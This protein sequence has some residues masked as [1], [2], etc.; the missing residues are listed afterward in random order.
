MAS[1]EQFSEHEL[2]EAL[3]LDLRGTFPQLVGFYQS[4][5]Y[6]F[7]LGQVQCQQSAEDIMQDSWIRIYQALDRYPEE[8]IRSLNLRPWLFTIV[9]NQMLTFVGKK[10]RSNTLSIEDLGEHLTDNWVPQPEDIIA[11]KSRI[12]EVRV[13]IEHMSTTY[14]TV[15]T[16]YLFNELTYQEIAEWLGLPVGTVRTRVSRGVKLLRERFAANVN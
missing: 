9:R 5:L 15:L 7:V 4:Q 12:E 8:K 3:A 6:G 1:V 10:N 2:L 16:L 13:I 11:L 14:C